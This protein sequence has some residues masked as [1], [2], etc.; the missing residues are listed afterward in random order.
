MLLKEPFPVMCPLQSFLE[1]LRFPFPFKKHVL[2]EASNMLQ[3]FFVAILGKE[4]F[5][6]E[7]ERRVHAEK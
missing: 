1:H 2:C 5:N 7:E 3:G 6:E 4:I